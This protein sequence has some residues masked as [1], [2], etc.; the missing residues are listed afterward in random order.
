MSESGPFF[1]TGCVCLLPFDNIGVVASGLEA[2]VA[3]RRRDLL[4]TFGA[5]LVAV[6]G[7][8][9]LSKLLAGA[10]NLFPRSRGKVWRRARPQQLS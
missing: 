4:L 6:H 2:H 8:A 1:L 9:I 5:M 7:P 10:A 3:M